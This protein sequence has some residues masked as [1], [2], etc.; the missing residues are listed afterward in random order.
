MIPCSLIEATLFHEPGKLCQ[1]IVCKKFWWDPTTFCLFEQSLMLYFQARDVSPNPS[2][3]FCDL[4]GRSWIDLCHPRF[5]H[6]G[7]CSHIRY[8][9]VWFQVF[10]YFS[11]IFAGLSSAW[12][13]MI[14]DKY[15]DIIC[16]HSNAYQVW[17]DL[18]ALNWGRNE[19][20][21]QILT[22]CQNTLRARSP[23]CPAGT[24]SRRYSTGRSHV[25]V[26]HVG[27]IITV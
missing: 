18:K 26:R 16:K 15:D 24:P 1:E 20:S 7:W 14:C 10:R 11:G 23:Y 4:H 9:D 13:Q 22:S 21:G 5:D 8:S 19:K 3:G 6:S 17:H 27:D 2:S 12:Y 25:F